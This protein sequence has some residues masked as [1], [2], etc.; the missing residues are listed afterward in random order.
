MLAIACDLI[1]A[2]GLRRCGACR[3]AVPAIDPL[4]PLR[5]S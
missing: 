2:M 1:D 3:C 4:P 5:P